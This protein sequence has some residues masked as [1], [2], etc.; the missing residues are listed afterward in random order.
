M[1]YVVK[2]DESIAEYSKQLIQFINKGPKKARSRTFREYEAMASLG[3]IRDK[4][5]KDEDKFIFIGTNSAKEYALKNI[6]AWEY[7][8]F[9]CCIGWT[10]DKC[11]IAAQDKELSSSDREEFRKYCRQMQEQDK[12]YSAVNIPPKNFKGKELCRAQ[13]ITLLQ[14]FT[15]TYFNMFIQGETGAGAGA[16]NNVA[17]SADLNSLLNKSKSSASSNMTKTQAALCHMVIHTA[18]LGCSAAAFLPIPV[19]DTI[20]ITSAQITMVIGL[21]KIFNKKLLKSDAGVILKTVAAPLTGR[22]VAKSVFVFVPGIGWGVN[23]A[24]AGTITEILGWTIANDFATHYS[25]QP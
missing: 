6:S 24:I 14:T 19:A 21:G 18:A 13:Y 12:A 7:E 10:G 22:A 5:V 25:Q 3:R 20:P 17:K 23:A 15:K 1:I 16:D 8:K 9:G 11:F 4:S 2:M